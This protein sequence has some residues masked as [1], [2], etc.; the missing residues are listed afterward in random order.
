L[1]VTIELSE[2]ERARYADQIRGDLGLEGQIRLKQARAIVIGAGSAGSAA[3]TQLAACG[4]GYV[5]VV[6]GGKV[7]LHDLAGQAIYYTPD[8]GESK[9]DTLAA[10][11]GLLN[12][13]VQVESYPAD[14]DAQN[15]SAIVAG[16]DI[17]LDCTR[18][19]DAAEAL[20]PSGGVVVRLAGAHSTSVAAG[21]T[22]A[23]D[24]MGTL[25]RPAAEALR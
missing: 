13:E 25:S 21:A 24:A 1:T 17:V 8:V 3:A 18:D 2:S 16:H 9:A 5:A 4:V 22:L 15:A 19:P 14:L 10:K 7:E 12:P 11:L 6:D 23:A 20:A